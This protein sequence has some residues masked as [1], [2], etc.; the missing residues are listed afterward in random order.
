MGDVVTSCNV[1][2]KNS[3]TSDITLSICSEIYNKSTN[4]IV[5]HLTESVTVEASSERLKCINVNVNKP[6]LWDIYTP[7]LYYAKIIITY[8]GASYYKLY[9]FGYRF[10]KFTTSGFYINGV[11]TKLKGVCM[12]H[13][14]GCI[15]AE[16]NV[17]AIKRQ[18]DILKKMGV[19]A[20]RITHNP[21]S[22]EYLNECMNSGI[23]VVEELFDCWTVGKKT[24]DFGRYFTTYGESITKDTIS[25]G[26]NNPSIIMWS[27][28]NEIIRTSTSVSS[29]TNVQIATN[30][31][32]WIKSQDTTRPITIGDDTPT[33][34]TSISIF[35]LVDV[36]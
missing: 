33:N 12:H 31:I 21:A 28:G 3:S 17:S 19:N 25:R 23:L 9:D 10:V 1:T 4:L 6:N 29:S 8:N 2:L 5:G 32:S 20:I 22:S 30:I 16:V 13:D 14:L 34:T 26:K 36:V 35:S 18:I 15:G 27:I 7:N 11:L 24:Y